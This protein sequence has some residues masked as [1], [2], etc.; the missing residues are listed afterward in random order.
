MAKYLALSN[1]KIFPFF[2][3]LVFIVLLLRTF[4]VY[5]F[6]KISETE[7]FNKI[8]IRRNSRFGK[9]CKHERPKNLK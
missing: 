7:H 4:W 3:S 8:H 9:N 6:G 1:S 2:Y 5:N